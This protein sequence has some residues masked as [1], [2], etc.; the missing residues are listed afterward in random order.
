[1]KK[2]FVVIIFMFSFLTNGLTKYAQ[3]GY[4]FQFKSLDGKQISLK[5]KLL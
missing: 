4:E 5:E 3:L 1:M 2:L